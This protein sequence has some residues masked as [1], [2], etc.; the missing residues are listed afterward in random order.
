M[1]VVQKKNALIVPQTLENDFGKG[2]GRFA[3]GVVG[4]AGDPCFFSHMRKGKS[5]LNKELQAVQLTKPPVKLAGKWLY[6][7]GLYS[8]FGHCLAECIHRLWAWQLYRHECCGVLFAPKLK[9]YQKTY[10][11]PDYIKDIFS[12][13]GLEEANI[14]Y[15]YELTEVDELII[16]EPGS[17]LGAA[18]SGAYLEFLATL[19]LD[20]QLLNQ[21][22]PAA[23]TPKVFVSRRNYRMYGSI[24][25][26]DAL[27]ASLQADGYFIFCPED[28]A[29]PIQLKVYLTA[30][31]LIF[32]EGSAV[33]LLELFDKIAADLLIINRRPNGNLLD[34]ILKPRIAQYLTYGQALMLPALTTAQLAKPNAIN[35]NPNNALSLIDLGHLAR[36]LV[37]QRFASPAL[38]L[39]PAWV[40]M[41]KTDV[42]NY[43]LKHAEAAT[44][45][46]GKVAVDYLNSVNG[47]LKSVVL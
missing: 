46:F 29:V 1:D 27:E 36:F 26:M 22:L 38:A 4:D 24:A 41:M 25:G 28:Y 31:K 37:Q 3:H 2:M 14:R 47:F 34:D 33:H 21:V 23:F 30:E 6:M 11:L 8:H 9:R 12:V 7:G 35:A 10:R 19:Q 43:L 18:A 13:F 44:P 5:V 16:P 45:E 32:E 15:I 42:F 20:K 17:Q 40:D 39:A